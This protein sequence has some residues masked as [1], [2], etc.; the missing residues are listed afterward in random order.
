[1]RAL[2]TI[3]TGLQLAPDWDILHLQKFST[4]TTFALAPDSQYGTTTEAAESLIAQLYSQ[5]KLT[6]PSCENKKKFY[7]KT[8]FEKQMNQQM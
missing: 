4:K 6:T 7:T 8:N 3:R 1:M 5:G 2:E